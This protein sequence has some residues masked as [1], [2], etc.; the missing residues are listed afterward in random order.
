MR[1][2]QLPGFLARLAFSASCALVVVGCSGGGGDATSVSSNGLPE[3]TGKCTPGLV[4]GFNGG[5]DDQPTRVITTG[6]SDGGGG[7][8]GSGGDGGGAPGAGIG[9]ALG[10]FA[11]VD[12]TAEFASGQ[13][14]GPIRVDDQKGMVTIVPCQLAPPVLVTM[15]GA[16][17]SGARYFDEGLGKNVPFE[18][19]SLRSV[20]TAFDKNA[21]VT[22][23]TE[24]MVRRTERIAEDEGRTASNGWNDPARVEIAHG[25]VRGAVNDLLPGELRLDDLRRLPV[26]LNEQNFTAGSTVLTDTQNG[27]YGA[28]LAGF[29]QTGAANL[30]DSGSP[31][32]EIN[33][34]FSTDM[35]DGSLDLVDAGRSVSGTSPPAYT[36]NA[37]WLNQTVATTQAAQTAG[38]GA[39]K[40]SRITLNGSRVL[41]SSAGREIVSFEM[42]HLSDGSLQYDIRSIG[43]PGR[44][45]TYVFPRVRQKS[46]YTAISQDGRTLYKPLDTADPC[47]FRFEVPFNVP[48][49]RMAWIDLGGELIRTTDGRFF[50][51]VDTRFIELSFDGPR[52]VQILQSQGII[53][54][55]TAAGELYRHD[56]TAT[57]FVADPATGGVRTLPGSAVKVNL[58]N[59]V[60]LIASS[61]DRRELFALTSAGEIYWL[62][63]RDA[64][65]VRTPRLQPRPIRL[66]L[67]DVCWISSG[68]VAVSCDGK[69]HRT[70][71]ALT[72]RNAPPVSV[73]DDPLVGRTIVPGV[74]G[75]E[76]SPIV[77]AVTPIWRSTDGFGL[78]EGTVTV[79][80]DI[81]NTARL[82][83]VDG[84]VRAL[85]GELVTKAAQTDPARTAGR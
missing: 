50:V 44:Q 4:R 67:G 78:A 19:K 42:R 15:T 23:F 30:G 11:N 81:S 60:K 18:G 85:N 22:S 28:V 31:A 74:R 24:A 73:V 9:G 57:G 27:R 41:I 5:F 53:W 55:V 13:R 3:F 40:S 76:I 52:M 46:L 62:D 36:L 47:V 51:S 71:K 45:L 25:Q 1:S 16:I 43:C 84:S 69:W 77:P 79:A 32:L 6:D 21:G 63:V 70:V 68:L 33:R 66:D 8:G 35:A 49:A 26:I 34:Q 2:I 12:V 10:Q 64:T 72:D 48:G 14:F 54:G 80:S 29:A 75:L 38:T 17:G 20:I 56:I 59:T 65:G 61:D 39:L 7:V 83:G 37:F 58:P 82:I